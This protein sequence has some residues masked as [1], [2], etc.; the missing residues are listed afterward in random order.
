MKI[1]LNH[2]PPGPVA[3]LLLHRR[4]GGAERFAIAV[5]AQNLLSPQQTCDA[6][7]KRGVRVFV[8]DAG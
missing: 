6:V 4:G 7:R 2:T 8:A 3:Q 1:I 5:M